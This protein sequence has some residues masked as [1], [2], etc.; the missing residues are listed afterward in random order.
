[1]KSMARDKSH[2][3]PRTGN[4]SGILEMR[5]SRLSR[6]QAGTDVKYRSPQTHP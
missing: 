5:L 6:Q 2:D 3:M 1:M 4:H